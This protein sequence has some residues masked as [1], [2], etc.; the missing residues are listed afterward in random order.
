MQTERQRIL[1]GFNEIR[2]TLDSEETR[3][4]Q[5]LEEDEVNVLDNLVV[6]R[7]QLARQKQ[8]LRELISDIEHQIWGSSAD[9]VQVSL[10]LELL[11]DEIQG[12]Y[13]DKISF[14]AGSPHFLPPGDIQGS[15]APQYLFSVISSVLGIIQSMN[16]KGNCHC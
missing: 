12:Q 7:D 15:W 2:A 1:K 16:D 5:K 9:T 3:V 10:G 13:R 14:S 6:A 8:C 11:H 4:L